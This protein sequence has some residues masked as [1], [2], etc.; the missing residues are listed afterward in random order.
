[1]DDAATRITSALT[2][3][4]HFEFGAKHAGPNSLMAALEAR[5]GYGKNVNWEARPDGVTGPTGQACLPWGMY[6]AA[7]QVTAEDV[8]AAETYG[9]EALAERFRE[10]VT[11]VFGALARLVEDDL[12]VGNGIDRNHN[13]A[14]YGLLGGALAATA[15]YANISRSTYPHWSANVFANGGVPRPLTTA[16]AT[17]AVNYCVT[18]SGTAPTLAV[19][20]PDA[21]DAAGKVLQQV[22]MRLS[23]VE[24]FP[25][26]IIVLLQPDHVCLNYLRVGDSSPVRFQ[27]SRGEKGEV[28]GVAATL[29]T[30]LVVDQPN[31]HAVIR[32]IGWPKH[33]C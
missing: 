19:G 32:D 7:F 16:L 25:R 6:R 14:I 23:N 26:G 30:Q 27:F 5:P 31:A 20:N 24:R 22:G 12:H 9:R 11:K 1:M 2:S 29:V 8:L 18:A 10:R 15:V 28:P 13:P 17:R 4:Y 21:M 33:D 3:T